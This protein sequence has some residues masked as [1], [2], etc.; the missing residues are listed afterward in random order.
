M[1]DKSKGVLAMIQ[2]PDPDWVEELKRSYDLSPKLRDA[3]SNL[4]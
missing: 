2:F 1:E 3:I 4:T